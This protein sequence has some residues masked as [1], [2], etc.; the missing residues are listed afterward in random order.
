MKKDKNIM[1]CVTQQK[2]CE[3]LIKKGKELRDK[4]DGEL[5]VV[6][7]AREDEN[8]LGNS[9]QADAI[10]YLYGISKSV[11]AD[12]TVLR[13]NDVCA[14]ITKF[15]TENGVGHIILGEPP[16]GCQQESIVDLLKES[17]KDVN[18]YLVS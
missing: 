11:G 8:F 18:F 1:V 12:M 10:E 13:S 9:K 4:I 7:V 6:H 15:A 17:M 2:T 3:R 14:A 16:K 5:H